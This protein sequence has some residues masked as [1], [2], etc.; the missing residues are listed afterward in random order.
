MLT[1]LNS[2]FVPCGTGAF[3]NSRLRFASWHYSIHSQRDGCLWGELLIYVCVFQFFYLSNYSD[4]SQRG[5]CLFRNSR[6]ILQI[7]LRITILP[8]LPIAMSWVLFG[9]FQIHLCSNLICYNHFLNGSFQF[10]SLLIPKER[11]PVE[12]FQIPLCANCST[13]SHCSN[14]A[15][16]SQGMG[17]FWEVQC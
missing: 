1:V 6:F 4:S 2:K 8:V 7:I 9:E 16:Y 15:T 14:S 12:E 17:A 13:S 11:V 5:G 10:D 3:G